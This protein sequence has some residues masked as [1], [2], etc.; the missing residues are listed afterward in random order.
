[1]TQLTPKKLYDFDGAPAYWQPPDL[2]RI[3]H[4]DS[5]TVCY[6]L[7]KFMHEATPIGEAE[8]EALKRAIRP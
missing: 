2:P 5:E 8:F 3:V 1:M 6:E 7:E 4:R